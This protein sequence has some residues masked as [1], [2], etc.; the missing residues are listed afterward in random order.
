MEI[1]KQRQEITDLIAL[2]AAKEA[3]VALVELWQQERS[4]GAASF[5][6]SSFEKLRGS[7]P[8]HP[9]R[10]AI[11]R[12]FTVEPIAPLLRAAAFVNGI[13]LVVHVG[14]FN[15]YAQEILDGK[16]TLYEFKP[17]TVILAVQ[18]RDIVPELW[19][20]FSSLETADISKTIKHTISEFH[21][22]AQAFRRQSHAHL[23]IH[24]L[25]QLGFSNQGILDNQS[26]KGQCASIRE[27]N[28]GLGEVVQS[29]RGTYIL[30]YD[31]LVARHGRLG[32]HDERKWL[33]V[34]LPIGAG[35]LVHMAEEWLRFLQPLAGK[36]AKVLVLDLDNTLWGG[37]I[38]ED[39]FDGIQVGVEYPGAAFQALQRTAMDLYRRGIL[40]AICSKNNLDEAMAVLEKHP[41]ML[42]RPQ[43]F[44]AM[45]INWQDKPQNLREI[46]AELNVGIDS[47]ALAD[48]NPAERRRVR[49]DIPEMTVID[50]PE[51]PMEYA[52]ALQECPA[53]ERL[54]LSAE[55]RERPKYYVAERERTHLEQ[56]SASREDFL[57][58]LRQQAEVAGVS[59]GTVARVAQLTQ[60]TNQFNLTTRRY[61]E[62]EIS[63][64]ASLPDCQVLSIR[65]K[66]R[67]ADNGLIGV[68]VTRDKDGVCELDTFLLSC[69]VIGRS[70]ETAL[71]SYLVACARARG[72][73]ELRG[74]FL[75]TKKNAPAKEFY[76][77]HGFV[78][79]DQ[80]D[81]GSLWRLDLSNSSIPCP[82]WV[83]IISNGGDH[84]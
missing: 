60:K 21:N 22:W 57:R 11:L 31:A 30:D 34:R 79:I 83:E 62:Q 65:V 36:I 56:S 75:P 16:S 9:Y 43:H 17:D 48:D 68:A 72:N 25:E 19:R 2:G 42:L 3:N 20:D 80:N 15:A 44:A 38:G 29:V 8:L 51:N 71:L 67:F 78:M 59:P 24:D 5:V 27:V 63:H 64:M 10:V 82:E 81:K 66:D 14:D 47:L 28:Q 32:W 52:Q 50:L 76:S 18:T 33:T 23:I 40:L 84:N 13:D 70:V 1:S 58:S 54:T 74:W 49:L 39:G 73:R 12:S 77:S 45:R 35:H 46:A 41:H 7:L 55:D 37:I 61:S 26:S 6:I 4:P 53:F 69:R